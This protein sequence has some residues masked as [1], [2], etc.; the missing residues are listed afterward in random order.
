[1]ARFP[2]IAAGPNGTEARFGC[3]IGEKIDNVPIRTNVTAPTSPVSF[4]LPTLFCVK[5]LNQAGWLQRYVLL[6][7]EQEETPTKLQCSTR[8]LSLLVWRISFLLCGSRDTSVGP[9]YRVN[10]TL[11]VIEQ[12]ANKVDSQGM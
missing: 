6:C 4:I 10:H 5:I 11:R 2:C 3:R 7:H 8:P 1:M 9:R 12:L